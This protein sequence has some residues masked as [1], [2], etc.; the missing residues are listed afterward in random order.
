M[1]MHGSIR[2][3]RVDHD[4]VVELNSDVSLV[5]AVRIWVES[6]SRAMRE[7]RRCPSWDWHFRVCA[8]KRK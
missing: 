6:L 4:A 8:W 2:Y 5:E 1:S 7:A 3:K